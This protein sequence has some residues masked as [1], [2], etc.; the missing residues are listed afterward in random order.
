MP[1]QNEHIDTL[2]ARFLSGEASP[3]EAMELEDWKQ[4]HPD[5]LAYYV[6]ASKIYVGQLHS[7]LLY[8]PDVKASWQ[9][10]QNQLHPAA[11]I[12]PIVKTGNPK[13]FWSIAASVSLFLLLGFLAFYLFRGRTDEHLIYAATTTAL[14][15]TLNDGSEVSINPNSEIRLDKNFKNGKRTVYLKGSASFSVV[16]DEKKPFIVDAGNIYI[17]DIGTRFTIR[18]SSD[19]DTVFIKVDEGVVLLFDS[20]GAELEIKAT[21]SAVYV[22][23]RKQ[24]IS[25][26]YQVLAPS[27]APEMVFTNSKLGSV[28]AELNRRY[29]SAVGVQNKALNECIITT[30]FGQEDLETVL[31]I[32]CETL[33]LTY[34]KNG[35]TYLIKGQACTP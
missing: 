7:A 18:Q 5:N 6:S 28:L 33:G 20:I 32:I 19:T 22:R 3:E 29:K 27:T 9:K 15:V 30:R 10:L 12:Q 4:Q 14:P 26:E 21:Q 34:E 16:H 8:E 1:E 2:I 13:R 11:S 24:I 23:S 35:K 25:P 31:T 17:K